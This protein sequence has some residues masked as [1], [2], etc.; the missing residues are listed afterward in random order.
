MTAS[1]ETLC[2]LDERLARAGH[3]PLTPWWREQL[4]RFYAHP[5]ARSFVGQVGRGGAKSHTSAKVGLNE[6]LFGDW[7]IPPGERHFWAFVSKSKDEA[8]QRLLLL[9]SFLR[10][11]GVPFDVDGD[12]IALR[13]ES[14]GFRVFACQ[15]GAVSGFR[16]YG[17][18][19]D[20]LA[21]W[22]AGTDHANPAAEVCSS[23]NAMAVTHP[24][25]RKL[26]I[27]SPFGML[28][29][30]FAR[31]G[32][33]DGA[34]QLVANAPSWVAN[35]QGITEEQTHA[36]EPS[37][38]V[39]LREYAAIPQSEASSAFAFDAVAAAFRELPSDLTP[40]AP[41][42]IIDF[43]SGRSDAATWGVVQWCW[44][45]QAPMY[46]TERK[47]ALQGRWY[48]ELVRDGAGDPIPNPDY[49]GPT[50]PL[51]HF[52]HVAGV[53]GTFWR[54]LPADQLVAR[55]AA[56]FKRLG[57]THVIGDQR[58]SF[59]LTSE[60]GRQGLRFT[61][62]AWSN[63]NKID[64][65]E[66]IRRWL[67]EQTLVLAPHDRLRSELLGFQERITPTGYLTYG[68]RGS[69][70]DDYAALVMTAAMAEAEGYIPSSPLFRRGSGVDYDH[71]RRVLAGEIPFDS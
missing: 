71:V 64:A 59:L 13:D 46:V 6:T 54:G 56:D 14:R 36:A 33:G 16:C 21:K 4:C 47:Y 50:P 30:H 3:S 26:L 12:Q 55:M 41:L 51:V 67:R 18:S 39:W 42:G 61:P 34:H 23:L 11:L 15:I 1:F 17:F 53:E 66:R 5:T 2:Q 48:D 43:S 65:V 69:S 9:Q 10:A 7:R 68:A 60:F 70:H 40:A 20:E 35:P 38:R 31:F 49:R 19:A 25:A 62:L 58:E 32:E 8:Q 27:S 37:E 28:D 29:Y 24:G 57:V 63:Q 22:Q 44:R 45:P 52:S